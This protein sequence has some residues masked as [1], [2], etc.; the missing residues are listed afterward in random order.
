[1]TMQDWRS[2]TCA[3]AICVGSILCAAAQAQTPG[4]ALQPV[5]KAMPAPQLTPPAAP[6]VGVRVLNT[7][8]LPTDERIARL[9]AALAQANARIVDLDHRLRAH[10][11]AYTYTHVGML[12]EPL[13]GR[14]VNLAIMPRQESSQTGAALP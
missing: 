11:H 2:A 9:E 1:M 8:A 12:S 5:L 4:S 10:H 3:M 13:N 14:T 6:P 7:A